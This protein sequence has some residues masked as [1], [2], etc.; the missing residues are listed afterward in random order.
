M[1]SWLAGIKNSVPPEVDGAGGIEALERK[2]ERAASFSLLKLAAS[3][4]V[5]PGP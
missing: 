5:S 2:S 3:N 4:N 1:L